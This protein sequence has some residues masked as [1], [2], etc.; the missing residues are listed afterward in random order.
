MSK[1]ENS[2]VGELI[3]NT[4]EEHLLMEYAFEMV[5]KSLLKEPSKQ[6]SQSP[7]AKPVIRTVCHKRKLS[8]TSF[9]DSK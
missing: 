9:A 4:I 3:K 5:L 7:E 8:N 1:A 6:I 2:I